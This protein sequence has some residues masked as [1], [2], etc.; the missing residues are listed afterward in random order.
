MQFL[1]KGGRLKTATKGV[2]GKEFVQKKDQAY[3]KNREKKG[4]CFSHTKGNPVFF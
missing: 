1:K 4:L 2:W 3:D